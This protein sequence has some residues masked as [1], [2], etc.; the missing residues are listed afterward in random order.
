MKRTK[1]TKLLKLYDGGASFARGGY[2]CLFKPAIQCENS[3]TPP[4]YVSKLLENKNATREYEYISRIKQKLEHIPIDIKKYLLIDNIKLCQPKPLTEEDKVS[5]D[6]TCDHI[7]S[8]ITDTATHKPINST[9][10]NNNLDKFKIINMPELGISIHDF[11]K[12]TKLSSLNLIKLNNIIIEYVSKIIPSIN[13]NG[14]IHGDIKSSNILFNLNDTELPTVIDWGLS[15]I[16]PS[17]KTKFPN[18]LYKLSVQYQH[19]FS[20]FL[21]SKDI[22]EKYKK[23]LKN[24]QLENVKIS[25]DSLRVFALSNYFNFLQYHENHFKILLG[26]FITGYKGDILQY[27][28]ENEPN[29]IDELIS[30]NILM[31]YIIEYIVDVLLAYTVNS[32]LDLGKY[33]HEVYS[34]NVDIWGIM[35]IYFELIY[36]EHGKYYMTNNEYKIFIN[37]I[38]NILIDNIFKNGNVK[39]DI[40]KLVDDINNLNKFLSDIHNRTAHIHHISKIVGKHEHDGVIDIKKKGVANNLS[41]NLLFYDDIKKHTKHTKHIKYVNL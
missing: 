18:A 23:F 28:T 24:L 33:F 9:T 15:Y 5:I 32:R 6:K 31:N 13:K 41:A 12:K 30:N 11:I 27:I 8:D 14:V 40:P 3:E 17:D 16:V 7:I 38:M 1:N 36:H 37:K 29:T 26:I 20:T 4:N 21:F 22:I 2:G 39:I 34:M 10:I 25:R 35:S 19:P